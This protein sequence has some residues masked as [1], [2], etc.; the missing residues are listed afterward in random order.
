MLD[1]GIA[2]DQVWYFAGPRLVPVLREFAAAAPYSNVTV[3]RYPP[4]A[5]D[6][7]GAA[8]TS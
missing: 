2:Y 7:A 5:A 3:H 6:L 4:R 8:L 1:V